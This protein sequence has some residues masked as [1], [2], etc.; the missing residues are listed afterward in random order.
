MQAAIQT[1]WSI[2]QQ[3]PWT[4]WYVSNFLGPAIQLAAGLGL[5]FRGEWI[6]H[7][8]V[9][10]NRPYCGQ[11]GYELSHVS[12][13]HCPECGTPLTNDDLLPYDRRYPR[14]P[15]MPDNSLDTLSQAMKCE[16][17][18]DTAEAIELYERIAEQW[19]QTPDADYATGRAHDLRA[20]LGTP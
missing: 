19:P 18:G 10:S 9:P 14:T 5:F 16:K 8:I 4:L 7:R 3:Q 1:A 6:V 17:R 20:R 15:P 2:S 11:C 12:G 13:G